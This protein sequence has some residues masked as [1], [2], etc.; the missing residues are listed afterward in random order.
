MRYARV[1]LWSDM[2]KKILITVGGTGGHVY[3]SMALAKQLK[4][5]MPSAQV[6]FVGGGLCENRYFERSSFPHQD[7]DYGSLSFKKPITSLK[8][9]WKILKGILQSRRII[10]EYQPDIVV[11][12]GSHHTLP[13]LLAAKLCAVPIVL[14]E[15]NRIPGRVNRIFSRYALLTGVHFPDTVHLLRGRAMEISIPLRQG[16]QLG[17]MSPEQARVYFQLNPDRLTLL[18]FGGSQGAQA[19]NHL[20]AEAIPKLS[21]SLRKR[22]QLLHF[23]GDAQVAQQLQDSYLKQGIRATVRAFESRMD[24]AWQAASMMISRAGAG[25]LAEQLEFEVPGILIPYPYAM[26]NHQEANADFMVDIVKG[27]VKYPEKK[28]DADQLAQTIEELL[29]NDADELKEM[30]Q[31]MQ[32]YKRNAR[33]RTLLSVVNELIE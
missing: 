28:L 22:L 17:K 27:A 23:T 11:G 33:A 32:Y 31:A 14:H 8:S 20:I 15:A 26:D 30:Q 4:Q 25:T 9:L 6:L 21:P 10:Q 1:L 7:I 18:I 2:G 3:P 13:T 16:Y 5:E 19:I 24:I 12:F 29:A